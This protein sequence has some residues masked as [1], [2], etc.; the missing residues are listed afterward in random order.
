MGANLIESNK[1]TKINVTQRR[2]INSRLQ[3]LSKLYY[4]SIPLEEINNILKSEGTQ[5]LQEDG[6]PF[7]GF[8]CGDSSYCTFDLEGISNAV[9]VLSWYKMV[10]GRWEINAYIS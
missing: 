8:L 2:R 9:L 3:S 1:S 6:T 4:E 5:I 7:S 10:S